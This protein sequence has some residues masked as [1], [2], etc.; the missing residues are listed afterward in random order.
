MITEAL[1]TSID[2]NS[3]TCTVRIPLFETA[4]VDLESTAEAHFC[5]LPGTANC[6]SK[7]DVVW[8]AFDRNSIGYPVII[9]KVYTGS[10]DETASGIHSVNTLIA[11]Q[12]AEIPQATK[13][14]LDG[15]T[16]TTIKALIDRIATL[17]QQISTINANKTTTD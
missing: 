15:E 1:I 16:T 14:V 3:T 17:E 2:Y 8:V 5:V 9:G 6:Y 12:A 4:G 7:N 10:D 11:T 13:I